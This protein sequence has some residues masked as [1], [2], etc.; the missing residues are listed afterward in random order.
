MIQRTVSEDTRQIIT[1]RR[2]FLVVIGVHE[3]I[4]QSFGVH[5]K[6]AV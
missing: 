4:V 2:R 6:Q 5:S 1:S 3:H